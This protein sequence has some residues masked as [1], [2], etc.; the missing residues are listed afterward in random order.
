MWKQIPDVKVRN[1]TKSG[2]SRE[3]RTYGPEGA[4]WPRICVSVQHTPELHNGYTVAVGYKEGPGAWW[5]E[6]HG[7][8]LEVLQELPAIINALLLKVKQPAP[9]R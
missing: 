2:P 6:R 7:M 8:P 9:T 5:S 3:A 4:H 1:T